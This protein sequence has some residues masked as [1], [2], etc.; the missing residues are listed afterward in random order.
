MNQITDANKRTIWCISKYASPPK[1]GV[2]SRLF[3]VSKGLSNLG[4]NVVL[5]SSN[6]NHL[7]KY[8]N[9]KNLYNFENYEKLTHVWLNTLKY[10]RS[11][12]FGRLLSWLDFDKKLRKVTKLNLDKP[13]FVLVSSLSLT[14]ILFGIYLK[15][16]YNVK[17]IFEIRDIY[18]LTLTAELGFSRFHPLVLY[19]RFIE[20]LGYKKADL[21]IGTMP[22]LVSHVDCSV[23]THKK[24]IYSPLGIP[25]Y[26]KSEPQISKYV[27]SLFSKR[28]FVVG[29]AG[30]IGKS[31]SLDTF[32]N[33]IRLMNEQRLKIK[34]VI[35]GDGELKSK[36]Q[37]ELSCCDNV[38]FGEKIEQKYIPQFLQNCDLLYFSV[39]DS[40]V[41]NYGLSLNKL[42]DYMMAA[43]PIVASF[44]GY[45][46]M[47]NQANCGLFVK[48]DDCNELRD[49]ILHYYN[50][51]EFE[52]VN[53]GI[54]GKKWVQDNHDYN[55]I[56]LD[57]HTEIL[58]LFGSANN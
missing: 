44:S 54:N 43:K 39:H 42:I 13:D 15:R 41:W 57:L 11:S 22:N 40:I 21:I 6:S 36:Y 3:Y 20:K 31:N 37:S 45:K 58:T 23:K 16:K 47:I 48:P 1:Y 55:K 2:G 35:I 12:S 33:T 56:T 50:M 14:T 9:S 7:S 18:P 53:I 17:L 30:S 29:Y 5:F 34:F 49:A 4:L 38:K 10:S 32:V 51:E 25:D 46:S 52:R 19:F 24:V 28:E 27:E 26:W 8:P